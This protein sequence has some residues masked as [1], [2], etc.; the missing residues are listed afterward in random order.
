MRRITHFSALAVF[1]SVCALHATSE[2]A[3]I[4]PDK[5]AKLPPPPDPPKPPKPTY[6]PP[7]PEGFH[8]WAP[9]RAEK[10]AAA[11][12]PQTW[13]EQNWPKVQ[14]YDPEYVNPSSWPIV[15]QGCRTQADW[16]ADMAGKTTQ[17]LYT[18]RYE[19]KV[20]AA[21]KCIHT[22]QFPAQG[23]YTV[24]LQVDAEKPKDVDV[25][26]RDILI[27]ALGDSMSSGEGA[28]DQYIFEGTP[29]REA[30]WVDRQCHRSKSAP[31]AQAAHTIEVADP[32]TSVTFLSFACSGATLEKQWGVTSAVFDTYESSAA[33]SDNAGSGI[34]G[35]YIGIESPAGEHTM[36]I[37]DYAA[38]SGIKMVSSQVFQLQQAIRGK[39]VADVIVMS[40]GINDMGFSRMLGTCVLT[41]T[42]WNTHVG[43][44]PNQIELQKRIVQDV[45]PIPTSFKR[46]ANAIGTLTKRT[47]VFEYPNGFTGAGNKTCKDA[48]DDVLVGGP[49]SVSEDEA[50]W[51]QNFVAPTLSNK[52][53]EGANAAGFEYITGPWKAFNGHGYCADDNQRWIMRA[54]DAAAAQGPK[55]RKNS[56]GTIHPNFAGYNELSKFIVKALT[57]PEMNERPVAR[58]DNYE[59][60]ISKLLKVTWLSGVLANDSDPDILTNLKVVNYT[61]PKSGKV[62]VEPDGA[63]SY[64]AYA[65]A[66][67]DSFLY[68]VSDGRLTATAR[69]NIKLTGTLPAP[70]TSPP[71]LNTAAPRLGLTPKP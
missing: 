5:V 71:T 3:P 37:E 28:P 38:R 9:P 65:Q 23:K 43:F 53:R 67:S 26:V 47:L 60:D 58:I 40:A 39:R 36:S 4:S 41:G 16:D 46:L 70:S 49:F 19:G 21:K 50:N 30:Q 68:T 27:I 55:L 35:T 13:P 69:V 29:F 48:L 63:F 66:A 54:I 15:A 45:A 34:L 62:Q 6:S 7:P 25:T 59:T 2:A 1:V 24:S 14:T 8:W 33:G 10:W 64:K 20:V 51:I 52:I 31:A 61:Q 11:W 12:R 44:Q 32:H 17:H 18:W 57:S 22:M 42:C 56:T